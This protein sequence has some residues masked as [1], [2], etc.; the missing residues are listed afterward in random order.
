MLTFVNQINCYILIIPGFG[1][2][3]T[4]ISASSSKP[5]FGFIGM[6]YA[7]MSIGI[8]G[9]IVWSQLV[10]FLI[11]EDKV[12]NFT[13][14]RY[15]YL[16][17]FSCTIISTSCFVSYIKLGNLLDTFYSLNSNRNVQS[18]GNLYIKQGSSE[19]IRENTYDLF[20]LNY[21]Y[22]FHE[23][24]KQDDDWLS[25]FVGFLEGDGAIL[26]H[27]GRSYFVLTQKYERVLHEICE[28]LKIGK[29]KYFYDN[30]GNY[31]Y[32][33]YIVSENKEIFLLYL[34]LNGNLV[35]QSR[36]NQLTKWN[37]ALKRFDYSLFYT[38]QV[39]IKKENTK[40]P[41]LD[42][43]WLSGF[44]DAEGGFSVK[45]GNEK[46][47]FYVS[48]LFIL[49]QKNEEEVLNKIGRLF[50]D[51]KKAI[52]RTR[53]RSCAL[54]LYNMYRL[55]LNCN[56][57]KRIISNKLKNYFNTYKLK[58]TKNKSF[59]IW[60]QILDIVINNQPLSPENLSK[61]RKLRH[62]MNYYTIENKPTGYA[63]KS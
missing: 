45:I 47:S 62:N 20:R 22:Y 42:G 60:V 63:N 35:L 32:S 24:F 36:I 57:K 9:F 39:P 51:N 54:S 28:I 43:A 19:T 21:A 44:T 5:V 31:K 40:Q 52:I 10:A 38:K 37:T 27:K 59:Y 25:W 26:E 29:V 34:L 4:T 16:I 56:D 8:L 3:S 61:V 12:I 49:D 11:R 18:A 41:G 23:D 2:I 1:I 15:G 53:N 17:L 55:S 6:I 58:T 46:A 30:K 14:G 13:V 50:S 33:R 48:L 7:M